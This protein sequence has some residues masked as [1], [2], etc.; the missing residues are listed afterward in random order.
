LI[1]IN[2]YRSKA[3]P[4]LRGALNDI[5]SI[6]RV[7]TT[8]YGFGAEHVLSLKNEQATRKGVLSALRDLTASAGPND[9]VY[10]HYSGHG[11][12]VEDIDGDETD[13]Q[14]DETLV[15]HDGRTGEIPDITDDELGTILNRLP[16]SKAI[17]VLDS[18]N[19]GTATRSP[20]ILTRSIPRDQR[21]ELYKRTAETTRAI[22]PLLSER[23]VLITGA[24]ANQPALDGPVDGKYRG[25]LSYALSRILGQA[26]HPL[27]ARQTLQGIENEFERIKIQLGRRSMPEPQLEAPRY[28][29]DEPLFPEPDLEAN[30]ESG[31]HASRPWLEVQPAESG[32]ILLVNAQTLDGL[33]GSSWAIYP[34]GETQFLPGQA[35]AAARVTELRGK[36]ALARLASPGE[37]VSA[38][39]RAI[40]LAKPQKQDPIPLHLSSPSETLLARIRTS[41]SQ[42]LPALL[43]VESESFARYSIN[44]V[45]DRC[46]VTGATG[47]QVIEDSTFADVSEVAERIS[48]VLSQAA[49]AS[50]LLALENP[51]SEIDL[52]VRLPAIPR[53]EVRR[54]TSETIRLVA[55]SEGPRFCI[56]EDGDLRTAQ[57]SLQLQIRSSVAGYLTIVAV[58]AQGSVSLLFP[59]ALQDSQYMKN[60]RIEAMQTVL[61]PDSL[62]PGNRAGFNWDLS[63]PAGTDTIRV[64][65]TTDE[66]TTV[67]IRD[68]VSELSSRQKSSQGVRSP[69]QFSALGEQLAGLA[70]AR[71]VQGASRT[72]IRSERAVKVEEKSH[73]TYG[74]WTAASITILVE[75]KPTTGHNH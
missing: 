56:R 10:I 33:P 75:A 53:K 47:Q 26:R 59:N 64:F 36:N 9:I 44:I 39:S 63:P 25:F 13:D 38:D 50:E 14:M 11:S 8:R 37:E 62:E 27:S 15:A 40:L 43:F 32:S 67:L 19:A 54:V 3:I 18:C 55:G 60:T 24:A 66:E 41:L 21:L 31:E 71:C 42:L 5:E 68:Y 12:Q 6:E 22:V 51:N 28:R 20:A 46:I 1:G 70:V 52:Q 61:I 7:L 17:I 74:D 65:L 49:G 35:V 73:A 2:E 58:D 45:E 34:P 16:T 57:N 30:D 23:H 4:D 48:R 69:A 72:P 29:L